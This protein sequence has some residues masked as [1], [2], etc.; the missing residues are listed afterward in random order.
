MMPTIYAVGRDGTHIHSPAA[1][2]D[3]PD[4]NNS[5]SSSSNQF[6]YQSMANNVAER[7]SATRSEGEGMVKQIWNDFLEDVLGPRRG[8]TRA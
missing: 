4:N 6:D 2:S 5:N 1:L 3:S 8:S 7:F